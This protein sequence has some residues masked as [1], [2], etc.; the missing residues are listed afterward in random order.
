MNTYTSKMYNKSFYFNYIN[1]ETDEGTKKENSKP[2][3]S[4]F[5]LDN[6]MSCLLF[7]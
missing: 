2:V 1:R 5:I 3:H 7:P 4:A 6:P